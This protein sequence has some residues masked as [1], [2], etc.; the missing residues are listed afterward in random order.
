MAAQAS[1]DFRAVLLERI[2][3]RLDELAVVQ[4]TLKKIA[5]QDMSSPFV[6]VQTPLV[7]RR[8]CT[9]ALTCVLCCLL[10]RGTHVSALRM[11]GEC[12]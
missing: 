5:A 9:H 1:S 3:A 11:R 2:R 12:L 10:Q 6:P 7:V 4:Q 8:P